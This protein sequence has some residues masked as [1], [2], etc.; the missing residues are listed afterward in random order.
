MRRSL[1]KSKTESQLTE[2]LIINH[3]EWY[4]LFI[5]SKDFIL[6]FS[7]IWEVAASMKKLWRISRSMDHQ[8]VGWFMSVKDCRVKSSIFSGSSEWCVSQHALRHPGQTLRVTLMDELVTTAR[9]NSS[10]TNRKWTWGTSCYITHCGLMTLFNLMI[11]FI[12]LTGNHKK[13]LEGLWII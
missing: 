3:F 11:Q 10:E 2:T 8:S 9:G 6:I 1:Q 13:N 5:L 4:C 12:Y 7:L